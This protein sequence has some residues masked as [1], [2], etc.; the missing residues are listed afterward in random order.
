MSTCLR[1]LNLD[2]P[3]RAS[4]ACGPRDPE[5]FGT[6]VR[7]GPPTR[8][9]RG[10]SNA[11]RR[12]AVVGGGRVSKHRPPTDLIMIARPCL[13]SQIFPS[14]YRG[15]TRL[16]SSRTTHTASR[17]MNC[18]CANPR[19]ELCAQVVGE[20]DGDAGAVPPVVGARGDDKRLA[21]PTGGVLAALLLVPGRPDG[22][23]GRRLFRRFRRLRGFRQPSMGS[24]HPPIAHPVTWVAI[25]SSSGSDLRLVVA[26]SQ[27]PKVLRQGPAPSSSSP[28]SSAAGAAGLDAANRTQRRALP[29]PFDPADPRWSHP[30]GRGT[31]AERDAPPPSASRHVQRRRRARLRRRPISAT[32]LGARHPRSDTSASKY[33]PDGRS[34]AVAFPRGGALGSSSSALTQRVFTTTGRSSPAVIP[35]HAP[36]DSHPRGVRRQLGR[37]RAIDSLR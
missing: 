24:R 6:G 34:S 22:A 28:S 20:F 2:G 32:M 17:V 30:S 15:A 14:V 13:P 36:R 18:A 4:R 35:G 1:T 3:R 21:T 29:A 37:A 25:L 9:W 12:I 10:A 7:G 33:P 27:H 16:I 19:A 23:P 8:R 26:H 31:S 5:P 11:W